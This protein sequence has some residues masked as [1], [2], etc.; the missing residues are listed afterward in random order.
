M[1]AL[2]AL[3]KERTRLADKVT[4]LEAR[5]EIRVKESRQSIEAEI[6]AK[7]DERIRNFQTREQDLL[8]SLES[9]QT[10]LKEVR[11]N[12]AKVTERLLQHGE[13]VEREQT[14]GKI[15]EL[16]V[17]SE[18]LSRSNER[19]SVVERRNEQ[20]RQEI[21][22]LKLG[23]GEEDRQRESEKRQQEVEEDNRRLARLLEE[24]SSKASTAES[25]LRNRMI[26]LENQCT[27][28]EKDALN[29][30]R[31]IQSM[32]DYEEIKRELEIFKY[33]EFAAD[34]NLDDK[35]ENGIGERAASTS[36]KPLETLLIE[37]NRQ[38]QDEVTNMR[39]SKTEMESASSQ[40]QKELE[41]AN[42][43]VRRLKALNER[44][45]DDLVNMKPD[46]SRISRK[47]ATPGMSAE[48]ALAEMDQIAKGSNK[49]NGKQ[50]SDVA[51]TKQSST[52]SDSTTKGSMN[53]SRG[54]AP[55][56][57]AASSSTSILPII[58][59]QRDRFRARNAE[60]EEELRKQFDTISELRTE[61]KTLQ[62]DNLGLYEKM[63]YLQ[64]Y[65]NGGQPPSSTSS[66]N[67]RGPGGGSRIVSVSARNDQ[68]SYPPTDKYRD[69]Y[70]AAMNP[71]EQFRGR[72]SLIRSLS[73]AHHR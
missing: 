53:G 13:E 49:E 5:L 61:V 20:L 18:E 9:T 46:D 25:K 65:G 7:W 41:K 15:E 17:I 42:S 57:D 14:N 58:T 31:R 33:V 16:E 70:E 19:V 4:Q 28:K 32:S 64:A 69:K 23:S 62:A 44:L 48:E 24:E 1:K 51:A 38:L 30:R 73:S 37:K 6:S 35:D 10:Q 59:S 67:F 52:P 50:S 26:E 29:L 45:E 3:E 27:D 22:R 12:Y 55:S 56:N 66:S 36:A 8:K 34:R 63:R 43:E 72:V 40:V 71:F 68:G 11:G 39:V 54:V 60:L 21:E 47:E 2:P